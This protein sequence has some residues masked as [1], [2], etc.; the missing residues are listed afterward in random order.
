MGTLEPYLESVRTFFE[1]IKIRQEPTMKLI[2]IFTLVIWCVGVESLPGVREKRETKG[3]SSIV[4]HR[5]KRYKVFYKGKNMGPNWQESREA[6]QALGGDLAE[7]SNRQ[8]RKKILTA[9]GEFPEFAKWEDY[10]IGIEKKRVIDIRG[11]RAKNFLP[12]AGYVCE[13]ASNE[14]I[15]EGVEF[16]NNDSNDDNDNKTQ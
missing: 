16:C 10:W 1:V 9:I 12:T 13:F 2:A 8:E 5:S 6:C 4:S 7:F 14:P 11:V 3:C 15:D